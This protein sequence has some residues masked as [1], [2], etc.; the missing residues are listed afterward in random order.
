ML[1]AHVIQGPCYASAF[2]VYSCQSEYLLCNITDAKAV[3]LLQPEPPGG[4][5][6]LQAINR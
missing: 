6:G 2:G 1:S 4:H 3:L 5:L